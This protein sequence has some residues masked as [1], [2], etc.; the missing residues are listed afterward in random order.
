MKWKITETEEQPPKLRFALFP[1][2]CEECYSWFWLE[3][4]WFQRVFMPPF[5]GN[6]L[7]KEWTCKECYEK[8]SKKKW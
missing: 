8:L 3:K 2:F 5:F 4:G 7:E 6:K 1:K